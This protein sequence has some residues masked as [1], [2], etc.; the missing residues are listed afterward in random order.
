MILDEVRKGFNH[1]TA[2]E[3]YVGVKKS[4]PRI[5]MGTVYRNLD[6]LASY[7]LIARLE[8]S[9]PQMRFD[10]NIKGHYHLTCARCGKIDDMTFESAEE[11]FDSLQ[12]ALGNLTKYGIFGHQLDF[13]GLCDE[14]LEKERQLAGKKKVSTQQLLETYLNRED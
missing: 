11:S 14:C 4:L 5:S 1:P 8:P 12:A 3:I 7:G 9:H 13:F 2:D 6:I 10:S